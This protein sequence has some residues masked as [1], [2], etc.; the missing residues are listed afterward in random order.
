MTNGSARRG[1]ATM[2]T[3]VGLTSKAVEALDYLAKSLNLSNT[4]AINQSILI[5]AELM[6]LNQSGKVV[7]VYDPARK[8][9]AEMM[10]IRH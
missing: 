8:K 3:S 4:D 6:K 7:E 2:R 10:I 5:N 9:R 1:A